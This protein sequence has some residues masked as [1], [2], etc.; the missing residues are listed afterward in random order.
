MG[1]GRAG[2]GLVVVAALVAL[3]FVPLLLWAFAGEWRFPDLLPS[4]WS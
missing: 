2:A 3:P 4:E 1:K